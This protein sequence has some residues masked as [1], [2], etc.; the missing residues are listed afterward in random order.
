M[1]SNRQAG[2]NDP[3]V[4]QL[5][6]AELEQLVFEREQAMRET[7]ETLTAQ[8]EEIIAM[9]EELVSQNEEITA[10]N[11]EIVTLNQKLSAINT[12]LERRVEERT[13][14]LVA[15]HQELL[16]QHEEI[17]SAHDE[18]LRN[19]EI[20]NAL[21]EIAEAALTVSLEQLYETIHQVV[22]RVLRVEN[23]YITLVDPDSERIVRPYSTGRTNNV[24][25]QRSQGKGWTEYVMRLRQ[26]VHITQPFLQRLLSAGEVTM[27][28]ENCHEWLG[29]PLCDGQG[30]CFGVIAI[31]STDAARGFAVDDSA[32][33]S[34]I[35]AQV[36]LAIER[37][38]AEESL[39]INENRLQRAQALA[40]VGNWEIDLARGRVWASDQA[41]RI[42]GLTQKAKYLSLAEI[43]TVIS[44]DESLRL[45]RAMQQLLAG[46]A[47]Y[48]LEFTLH[49]ADDGQETRVHSRAEVVVDLQGKPQK[50]LGVIQ[51]ITERK[52]I[53]SILV[54]SEARYRAVLEQAP[55]AIFICDPDTGQIIETNSRF[56]E[57]FGYDLMRHGPLT[58]YDLTV[59]RP[60]NIDGF[61][62][63]VKNTGS[64]P[65]Q[66]R[67][68]RHRNG[69]Y[70]QVERSGTLVRYRDRSVLVQTMRDVS[71]EVRREQEIRRDAELATRVQNALLKEASPSEYLEVTTV[72]EP[73][74]YVGGDLYFMD[75]RY[76]GKM[77][78]GFLVDAAGHGLA[79]ALHTSAMHVLLREVNELDLPLPE[80]MRWL[81]R[82]AGQYF[83]DAAFAGAVGFELDLETRQLRWSCAGMPHVWLAGR[84]RQGIVACPGMYLG[85]CTSEEFDL[86]TLPL[87]IG[88]AVCFMTDGVSEVLGRNGDRQPQ[89]YNEMVQL[90]RTI[91][92]GK[93][94][95]DDA[96]AICI[97]VKSLP[98]LI[99]AKDGWPRTLRFN[100]YG[101]YQRLKGEVR[102]LLADV[103]GQEHS[104]QEVAVHEALA[105]A[106]ECR[107]GVARQHQAQMRIHKI[108]K[109]LVVRVKTSRLGF[110]GNALLR[111]LRSQGEL[112]AYGEDASMGR[113]IPIMLATT[114]RMTYNS[115]G[116][117]LLLAWKLNR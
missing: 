78:R 3:S 55:E 81:N 4:A 76:G 115:E 111:R 38:R 33:L 11:E 52:R 20:Q 68:V 18:L 93:E 88:D 116:T 6:R 14:E 37:K 9:N 39:Q 70:V 69:S 57:R 112:F 1:E 40:R 86:Q 117:E 34:I 65:L 98:D 32:V 48:D 99:V 79:T 12:D 85:L 54:D 56:A 24:P 82:R 96:T 62:A 51:D 114:H 30:E 100:G 90:L 36:S 5:T 102:K 46:T 13:S 44:P 94:C 77:L 64:L 60:E 61:L 42:Y 74:S 83:D 92:S 106:M 109:W 31:F 73:H 71:E 29:A 110:A 17:R 87:S 7:R 66:R 41:Y 35:A 10:M 95:H 63:Q 15:A 113:G 59:D 104:L 80:Q 84:D 105:N 103:T 67:V 108:G 91:A 22:R 50:V 8:N 27:Q 26:A 75:W 97:R 101:D 49:R 25:Q 23:I 47:E 107:D 58:V 43:R 28:I 53:E 72:Y 2:S 19:A 16:A 21:R 89:N 45:D